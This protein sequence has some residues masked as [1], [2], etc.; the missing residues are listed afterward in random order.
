MIERARLKE[1]CTQPTFLAFATC[2]CKQYKATYFILFERKN[3]L[4]LHKNNIDTLYCSAHWVYESDKI[5]MTL[6]LGL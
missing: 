4:N 5:E 6:V 1:N 2:I 3:K